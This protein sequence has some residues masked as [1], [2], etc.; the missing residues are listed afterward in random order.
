[1]SLIYV[2]HSYEWFVAN[3]SMMPQFVVLNRLLGR[4]APA[5]IFFKARY[6]A[7]K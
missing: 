7:Y 3:G 5:L 1:M 6:M 4:N 2:K